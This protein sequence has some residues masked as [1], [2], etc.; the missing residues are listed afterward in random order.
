M[1]V[2]CADGAWIST[3]RVVQLSCTSCSGGH[4]LITTTHPLSSREEEELIR[5]HAERHGG[6]AK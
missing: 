1:S 6:V 2:K 4:A 3:Q 5:E